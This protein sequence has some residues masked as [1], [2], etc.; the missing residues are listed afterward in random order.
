MSIAY[1]AVVG[2]R[3]GSYE[4]TILTPADADELAGAYNADDDMYFRGGM[5]NDWIELTGAVHIRPLNGQAAGS[6]VLLASEFN[7]RF[8]TAV[9]VPVL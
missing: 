8:G 7:T 2:D 3:T 6:D 1:P 5:R 9:P 4:A